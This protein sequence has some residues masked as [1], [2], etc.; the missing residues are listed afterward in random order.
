MLRCTSARN[1]CGV[2]LQKREHDVKCTRYDESS[3][4]D[5]H[6][7]AY[8]CSR[9]NKELLMMIKRLCFDLLVRARNF[10]ESGTD[11]TRSPSIHNQKLMEFDLHKISQFNNMRLFIDGYVW[12]HFSFNVR[13]GLL[14]IT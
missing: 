13:Y 4:N 6:V 9:C 12:V 3:E 2:E 7:Y 14:T 11:E 10:Y 5:S 1:D 8:G